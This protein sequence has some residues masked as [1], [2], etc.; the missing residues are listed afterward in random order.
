MQTAKASLEQARAELTD[1]EQAFRRQRDLLKQGIVAQADFDA[2]EARYKRAIAGVSGGDA[3]VR[4]SVAACL[5]VTS[6]QFAELANKVGHAGG[7]AIASSG[8][9]APASNSSTR[10]ESFSV[11]RE[12]ITQPAVPPPT[13]M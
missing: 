9:A 3:G 12:A 5:T 7:T 6:P 10:V 2:A 8:S 4:N 13:T 1:A 11:S